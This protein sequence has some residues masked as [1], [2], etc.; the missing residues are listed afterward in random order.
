MEC[1]KRRPMHKFFLSWLALACLFT[2]CK[3]NQEEEMRSKDWCF[4]PEATLQL[5]ATTTDTLKEL[6][7]EL[8]DTDYSIQLGMMYREELTEDQGMLFVFEE[9]TPQFFY[10]KNTEVPLDIIYITGNKRVDSYSLNAKPKD[11]TLLKSKGAAKYVLE[12]K[13]G[14]VE[15]WGLKEGDLVD[16][17]KNN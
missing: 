13:A 16:W 7:V 11:E 15:Q 17:N 10:L 6:Q 2:G 14:M 4:K 9:D 8:A 3:P 1:L 5:I 12:V